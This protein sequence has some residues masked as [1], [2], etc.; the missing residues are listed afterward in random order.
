MSGWTG[1]IGTPL[2]SPSATRRA[3]WRCAPP[4]RGAIAFAD[5]E[6]DATADMRSVLAGW[7]YL[8]LDSGQELPTLPTLPSSVEQ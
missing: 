3:S 4:A 6:R 1:R 5:T 2:W 7:A 8:S